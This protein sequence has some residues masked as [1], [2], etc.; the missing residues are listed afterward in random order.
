MELLQEV[1]NFLSKPMYGGSG[2]ALLTKSK[3]QNYSY[4]GS[5]GGTTL[6]N[7]A[8]AKLEVLVNHKPRVK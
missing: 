8:K 1:L 6:G 7:E 4:F 5:N 3:N 2:R